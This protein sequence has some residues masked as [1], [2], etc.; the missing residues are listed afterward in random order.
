MG[1]KNWMFTN[2]ER[3]AQAIAVVYNIVGTTKENGLSSFIYLTYLFEKLLRD[4]DD[5][6]AL[7]QLLP[8]LAALPE[9]MTARMP[10]YYFNPYLFVMWK[11]FYA[12]F[13][14]D[15]TPC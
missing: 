5:Q 2:T 7:D 8:L 11:L 12:N 14:A 1:C 10:K 6:S 4:T 15:T 13:I 9:A 3:G